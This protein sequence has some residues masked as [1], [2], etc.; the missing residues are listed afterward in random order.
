MLRI[1][2]KIAWRNLI[3]DYRFMLL[4]IAGLATGLAC[5]LIIW[6]W[7]RDERQVDRFNQKDKQ[8]FQILANWQN[9]SGIETAEQ[10]PG[11]LASSL[12]NEIPEI[13]YATAVIPSSWFDSKGIITEKD[14]HLNASAQFAGRDFFNIFS[15]HLIAGNRDQ[16]LAEKNAVVLSRT[17]ALKL[18]NTTD[19]V[20]GR[21]ITWNLKDYNGYYTVTGIFEDPP[22]NATTQFDLLF[23]YDLFLEKNPKLEKWTNFDPLTYVLIKEGTK[24]ELL[25]RKIAGF[26]KD[27]SPDSKVSLILQRY[28]DRYLYNRYENG[29]PAGGRIEYLKL[30]SIIAI[31]ILLIACIN[32]MNLGTAKAASRMKEV[33]VKKVMGARRRELIIQYLGESMLMSLLS[34]ILAL[35][36]IFLFLPTFNKITGKQLALHFDGPLLL[37]VLFTTLA[38]GLMAGSYPALYLSGFRPVT[39]LKGKLKTSFSDLIVRK[40]LVIFQF[41]L[42]AVFMVSVLIVYKQMRLI[43]TKN[44]GYHRDHIIWFDKGGIASDNKEDYKQ[45]GAYEA[46]LSNFLQKLRNISGVINAANFRHNIIN[47]NGGTSDLSWEGKNP[48]DKIDFTDLGAG[49]NFIETL[50]IQMKEGRSFSEQ[51]GDEK[52]KI[53]FNEAAIEIMGLKNPVGKIVHLWGGD[54]QIIGVTKNFNF[55]SLHEKLKPCFFDLTVNQRASKIMVK[56]SAGKEKETIERIEQFYKQYHQGFPL[57]YRFLDSDFQQLYSSE[58]RIAALSKYFAAIALIISCLG[59]FGLSAFTAQKRQKEISIRKVVGASTANVAMMLSSSF[60]KLTTIALLIAFPVAYLIIERWLDGFAYRV[61]AGIIPFSIAGGSI[62]LITLVTISFHSIKAAITSPVK[63]LRS[64]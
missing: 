10:T 56:I 21:T 22:V 13:D 26:V 53:I 17:M 8:L 39:A 30:F 63:T 50:G 19:Q 2:L 48:S 36:L 42:S 59:L 37:T 23:S 4:N 5:T 9:S 52:S 6:L 25:N 14:K 18:F 58:Q 34:A 47:R 60:L 28:S 27:K 43:Q 31:F 46:D 54:R 11:L 29:K 38:A 12:T 57:E 1:G 44:L 61:S 40:G 45:G 7:I 64:E 41:V 24:G 62:I 32:F 49:Y 20:V 16:V 15:Y 35:V 3:R 33:G 51:Y 55:Q